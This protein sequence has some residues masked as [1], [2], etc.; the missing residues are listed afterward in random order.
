MLFK[1]IKSRWIIWG[2]DVACMGG[3]ERGMLASGA[4]QT[5]GK[6]RHRRENNTKVDF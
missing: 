3:Q 2:G 4:E 6:L 5:P 1:E